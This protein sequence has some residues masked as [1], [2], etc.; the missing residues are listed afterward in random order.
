MAVFITRCVELP[1]SAKYGCKYCDKPGSYQVNNGRH[2]VFTCDEHLKV[3]ICLIYKASARFLP[4]TSGGYKPKDIEEMWTAIAEQIR[5]LQ[6]QFDVFVRQSTDLVRG[7][8]TRI[9]KLEVKES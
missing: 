6:E 9:R 2:Q 5:L 8:E 4:L 7:L 3:S 1:K